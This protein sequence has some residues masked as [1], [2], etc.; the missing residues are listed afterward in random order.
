MH[1]GLLVP[2]ESMERTKEVM[3][4]NLKDFIG[5]CPIITVQ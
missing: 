1:D 4:E 3:L 5:V 2:K